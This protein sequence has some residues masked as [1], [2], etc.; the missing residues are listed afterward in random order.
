MIRNGKLTAEAGKPKEADTAGRVV[1]HGQALLQQR[2]NVLLK[3]SLCPT[4]LL[5]C[6]FPYDVPAFR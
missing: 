2:L 4:H 6:L 3:A 5:P 1:H